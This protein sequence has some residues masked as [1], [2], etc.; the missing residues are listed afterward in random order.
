MPHGNEKSVT[1]T[2]YLPKCRN[3]LL[4]H[5]VHS[6]TMRAF[7]SPRDELKTAASSPDNSYIKIKKKDKNF[8]ERCNTKGQPHARGC[9]AGGTLNHCLSAAG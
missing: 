3:I 1:C 9:T 2:K 5:P 4:L 8:H 7:N 6:R